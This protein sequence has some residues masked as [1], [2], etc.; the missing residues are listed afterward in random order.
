MS[1]IV[2]NSRDTDL[3]II[4][5]PNIV[6]VTVNRNPTSDNKV[7]NKK[8]VDGSIGDGTILKFNQTI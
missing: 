5:L 2:K 3:S 7:A 8:Y 6:S 1:Y 4:K